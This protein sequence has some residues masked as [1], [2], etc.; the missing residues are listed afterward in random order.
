MIKVFKLAARFL[1]GLALFATQQ[2][3][4]RFPFGHDQLRRF[5]EQLAAIFRGG[6]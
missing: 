1:E 5:E 4:E 3:S 2:F 6:M